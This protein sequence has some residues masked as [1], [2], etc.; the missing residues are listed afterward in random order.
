MYLAGLGAYYLK[1]GQ[2]V[3]TLYVGDVMT[4]NVP[5]YNQVWLD[6]Y[7][8]GN[9]QFS[10]P[11]NLPMPPYTLLSRDVG[12]FTASVFQLSPSGK[13]SDSIG[14]DTVKVVATALPSQA[15]TYAPPVIQSS[16]APAYSNP[17][18]GGGE[19]R[20]PSGIAT[21]SQPAPGAPGPTMVVQPPS[22]PLDLSMPIDNGEPLAPVQESGF[23]PL[24]MVLIAGAAMYFLFSGSKRR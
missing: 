5:G 18:A 10:G 4:F 20:L 17:T 15:P 16:L 9:L 2:P 7:Q 24:T 11:M 23:S 21:P 6:Q 14:T 22:G 12:T 1:N 8:N 13:R 19:M 3:T